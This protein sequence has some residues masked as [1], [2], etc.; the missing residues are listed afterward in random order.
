MFAQ[1][2]SIEQQEFG[3]ELLPTP[4]PLLLVKRLL[5]QEDVGQTLV[6]EPAPREPCWGQTLL[7]APDCTHPLHFTSPS[8]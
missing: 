3:D 4:K 6:G 8:R 2:S 5:I 7:W 1:P